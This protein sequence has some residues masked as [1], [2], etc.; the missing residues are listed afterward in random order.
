MTVLADLSKSVSEMSDEELLLRVRELRIS[1]AS[2][3]PPKPR[4]QKAKFDP[5]NL[6]LSTLDDE[7]KQGLLEM[8]EGL[9]DD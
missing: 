4:A 6:D 5:A 2:T 3:P 1:R 8:L 7:A 9:L